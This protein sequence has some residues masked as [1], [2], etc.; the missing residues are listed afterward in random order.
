MKVSHHSGVDTEGQILF[1]TPFGYMF[2]DAARSEACLLPV[3]DDT[4]AG[5]L[6]LGSAMADPGSQDSPQAQFDSKI[7]AIM[8]YLGQFIDHDLTARTDREAADG[9]LSISDGAGNPRPGLTPKDPD[10]IVSKVCNAR[11]P[12]FDLDS[13]YGDGPSL[14]AALDDPGLI[15]TA[16][17][18]FYED[19]RLKVA[20]AQDG[21]LDLPRYD[22]GD[23]AGKA[24]IGDERND[25][26]VNVSQFHA[27]L[28][29]FNNV[30]FESTHGSS[31]Q[32]RYSQTRRLVRWAYQYIVANEFLPAVCDPAIVEDVLLNGPRFY[33]PA[34]NN[35]AVFM[36]LEFSVAGFRFAHS[37]IR[38]FYKLNKTVTMN[39]EDILEPARDRGANTLIGA[40]HRLKPDFVL[41]W[42]NFVDLTADVFGGPQ[43]AR[44]IDPRLAKG[45]NAL[46]FAQ[47]DM[48]RMMAML[49]QRNL[50]RGYLFSIPTGQAVAEQMGI[51]PMTADQVTG[52][53]GDVSQAIQEGGFAER[54]PLW[55]YILREA[56]VHKGGQT[57]GA[58]GSRLVAEV[59]IG[60]LMADQGSY[61][62]NAGDRAVTGKGI[63]ISSGLNT[64]TIGSLADMVRYSGLR[65]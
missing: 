33:N 37:M 39:I 4:V 49:A 17:D 6:K 46:N 14:I 1:S 65:K 28:L 45:L 48:G 41:Q 10:W 43:M 27:A 54:T 62:N 12:Q 42:R 19:L 15:T 64:T 32:S 5:L 50:L 58:V 35:G 8:T 61:L 44:L 24:M 11:R 3:S 30:V 22:G 25:E 36:P 13:L 56:V 7:P 9:G 40:D 29:R 2:E 31:A 23:E 20:F 34:A 47:S 26:N 55:F 63:E 59:I 38:P 21:Y 57:L 18:Q 53:D 60:L 16:A 51:V 52:D